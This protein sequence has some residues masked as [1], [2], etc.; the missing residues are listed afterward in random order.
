MDWLH[1]SAEIFLSISNLLVVFGFIQGLQK[2][3]QTD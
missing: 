1:G 3:N 2:Q